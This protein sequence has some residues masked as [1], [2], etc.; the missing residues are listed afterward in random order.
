MNKIGEKIKKIRELRNFSRRFMANELAIS[1][2][3]YGKI[4]RNETELTISRLEQISV[5]LN[6]KMTTI[7]EFDENQLL[8]K[9]AFRKWE[10]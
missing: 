1:V 10:N 4:E 6:V 5:V 7:I 9:N 3:T 8:D 2:T